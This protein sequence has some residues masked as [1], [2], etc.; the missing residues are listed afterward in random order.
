MVKAGIYNYRVRRP[1]NDWM[2]SLNR[3]AENNGPNFSIVYRMYEWRTT[4]IGGVDIIYVGKSN[5]PTERYKGKKGLKK[6]L[7]GQPRYQ[8]K[9]FNFGKIDYCVIRGSWREKHAKE[10]ECYQFHKHGELKGLHNSK[11]PETPKE[12]CP[13]KDC[14]G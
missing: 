10:E 13:V 11:H 5:E 3:E 1:F 14:R 2:E 8:E 4:A 9:S 6:G 7:F 12:G